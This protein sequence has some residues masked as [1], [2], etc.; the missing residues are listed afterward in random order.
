MLGLITVM[1]QICR[2]TV[3]DLGYVVKL[4]PTLGMSYK[5]VRPWVYRMPSD[6]DN[7]LFDWH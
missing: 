1:T 6:N 4:H 3:A 2:Y 7:K 5:Y